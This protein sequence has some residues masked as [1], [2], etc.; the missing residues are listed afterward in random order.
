MAMDRVIKKFN[1]FQIDYS[2]TN[3]LGHD[4]I[5]ITF[6][7]DG[8]RVG[9]LLSGE[10]IGPGS[11]AALVNNEIALYFSDRHIPALL[12]LLTTQGDLALFVEPDHMNPEQEQGSVGGITNSEAVTPTGPPPVP[13][14][15]TADIEAN[16]ATKAVYAAFRAAP[17]QVAQRL[18]VGQALRGWDNVL[19]VNQPITALTGMGLPAPKMI[20]IDLS[21]LTTPEHRAQLRAVLL[22]HSD[23]GGLI[24]LSWHADNPFTGGHSDD[25]SGVDLTELAD[26]DHPATPG[27]IAWAAML[28][29]IAVELQHLADAGAVVLFRPFHESNGNWF[30]W[31]QRNP[32]DFEAAWRGL[33][34]YLTTTKGFHNLLWVY[35]A[36]RSLG[37]AASDPTRFFPGVDVVDI[38]G[39]DIYDDDLSDAPP[40]AAGY[41]AMVGLAR[42]FAITEYGAANFPIAHDGAQNLP[43]SKVLQLIKDHYP[44]TV[45]ASAWYSSDGNN[46]QISDK[47]DPGTL[48]SDPWAITL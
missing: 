30:W 26:P 33:F 16:A 35:A 45:L 6:F 23:D 46:W 11:Y 31:G 7:Q 47:P 34:R 25:R 4:L 42:P 18:V 44:A 43:N 41:D 40:D 15:D 19:P 3:P 13:D 9:R 29:G 38:V 37:D 8:T 32:A 28:D 36:N 14:S 20:E 27:A 2:V 24:G 48:L 17:A 5:R 39:L 1:S 22:A 12:T 21:D 10:A